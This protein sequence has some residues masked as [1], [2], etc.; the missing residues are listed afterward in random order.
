MIIGERFKNSDSDN[1]TIS[2]VNPDVLTDMDMATLEVQSLASIFSC[3]LLHNI[4]VG[5]RFNNSDSDNS[6]VSFVNPDVLTDMDMATLKVQSLENLDIVADAAAHKR[7]KA[8]FIN[9]IS[10]RN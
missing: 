10:R 7:L 4:K 6:T 5:E 9:Y 1:L 8:R 2:F 3:V